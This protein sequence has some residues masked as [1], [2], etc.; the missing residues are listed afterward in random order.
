MCSA[1]GSP[2]MDV[3]RF[4][5]RLF[6]IIS[7]FQREFAWCFV[8]SF[9]N[10]FQWFGSF[11]SWTRNL[12][13]DLIWYFFFALDI[14]LVAVILNAAL[15][16]TNE[17]RTMTRMLLFTAVDFVMA[18]FWWMAMYRKSV[19]YLRCVMQCVDYWVEFIWTDGGQI[20]YLWKIH[21]KPHFGVFIG[22]KHRVIERSSVCDE[23][24]TLMESR[25]R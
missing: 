15:H 16:R 21:A 8:S 1:C 7:C 20:I 5:F 19:V 25:S 4:F 10:E 18:P 2:S 6:S 11:S 14:W 13:L 17:T 9:L 24:S 12:D 3:I 23:D 22:T